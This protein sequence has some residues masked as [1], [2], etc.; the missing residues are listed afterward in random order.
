MRLVL[1]TN[2]VASALLSGGVPRLLLQAG[3]DQRVEIF[4]SVLLPGERRSD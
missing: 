1:D 4:T 3:R 2:I